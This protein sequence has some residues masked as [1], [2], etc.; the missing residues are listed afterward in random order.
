[1]S[2]SQQTRRQFLVASGAAGAGLWLAGCGGGGGETGGGGEGNARKGTVSFTTWGSAAEIAAFKSI[3]A[4]FERANP[5]AK[6]KLREVPFE[7]V[8]DTVD[9]GLQGG[10]PTDLFRVTY[11]D[12]GFYSSQNAL[13]DMSQYL[14]GGYQQ[15]F[16][17][18]LWSAVNFEGKPYGV[19]HHTDVSA[20][21]YNKD[22]LARAGFRTLPDN[23]DDAWTWDE[24]MDASRKVKSSSGKYGHGMNWTLAGAYRWLNFLYQAGGQM[25][26]PD[27]KQPA[28]DSA[29]GR[30]T[31]SLFQTWAQEELIPRNNNPKGAYPDEFFPSGLVGMVFAGDFLLPS[32]KESVKKFEY[33][34][35]PMPRDRAAATD[36]GGNAVVVTAQSKHQALAARFATHL[37]DPKQMRTFCEQTGTLPSR[38]SLS[39]AELAFQ[40]SPELMPVYQQQAKTL[41]THLV[42]SVTLPK[43]TQINNGFVD[44][45]GGL[46]R[47]TSVD[48]TL[49][50][51]TDTIGE[52]LA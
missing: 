10:D 49:K 30:K 34:V 39:E 1:M 26:S 21:I 47:G 14:P 13:A 5:G 6:V 17:P 32:L 9:A 24:F 37:A 27:F 22:M 40:V 45:I 44:Q 8:R 25:L 42:K 2:Q 50:A 4:D 23:V 15:D 12:I 46:L 43:F 36:L 3:I 7:Q 16:I 20:L 51:M 28:V 38:T 41:P 33:G 19:P 35:T 29:A 11:Q 48:D 52:N 31:L 18:A